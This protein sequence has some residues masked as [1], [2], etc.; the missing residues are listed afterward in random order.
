M[1]LVDVSQANEWLAVVDWN[2]KL[3]D[4]VQNYYAASVHAAA[5]EYGLQVAR[6]TH[7]VN[8]CAEAV[9][10][11]RK[12]SPELQEQFKKAHGLARAAHAT[13]KHDNDMVYFDK[14][15]AVTTLPKLP[16]AAMVRPIRLP[17]LDVTAPEE[18]APPPPPPAAEPATAPDASVAGLAARVQSVS[19][20]GAGDA[21]MP[22]PPPPPPPSFDEATDAGMEDLV[23]MGFGREAAQ[24]ALAQTGG[25]VQEASEI[26]LQASST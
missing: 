21:L 9:N 3:F 5:N 16:R 20:G 14:V 6:L 7:A 24:A 8:K 26:L 2:C 11:C 12:A 1:R 19:L 13:A 10:L 18:Q 17:E 25:S 4:G 23:A 22:G 15:P